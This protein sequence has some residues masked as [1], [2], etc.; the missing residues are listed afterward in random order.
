MDTEQANESTNLMSETYPTVA[1]MN[2]L[3]SFMSQ[4]PLVQGRRSFFFYR[5][6]GVEKASNG[7][8][9]A[10][11][12]T[13]NAAMTQPTGWHYHECE[14]QFSYGIRGTLTLEFE[15]GTVAT[16]GPGDALF[17]PGGVRHNEIYVSPDR[18][19]LEISIPG[20]NGYGRLRTSRGPPRCIDPAPRLERGSLIATGQAALMHNPEI[21]CSLNESAS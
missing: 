18:E 1:A 10:N 14:M 13:A 20:K 11:L 19:A 12:I 8:L 21:T 2:I 15:D 9:R 3:K 7:R 16:F 4:T 5:D 6:L 17:I